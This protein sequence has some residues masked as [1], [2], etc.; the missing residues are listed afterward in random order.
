MRILRG[1]AA[2]LDASARPYRQRRRRKARTGVR[3]RELRA[4]GAHLDAR[5]R[6]S[7][8]EQT[9]AADPARHRQE[10]S[11]ARREHRLEDDMRNARGT[12]NAVRG[13]VELTHRRRRPEGRLDRTVEIEAERQVAE[14]AT[15][16]VAQL[17]E[18]RSPF[19]SRPA[20]W[21][22]QVPGK[23]EQ[24]GDDC[25]QADGE[26][27]R[28]WR[29][30]SIR[31]LE[32]T[33][34][35]N[36][37]FRAAAHVLD[38]L[39]G[40]RTAIMRNFLEKLVRG[41]A[42]GAAVEGNP[43]WWLLHGFASDQRIVDSAHLAGQSAQ[44]SRTIQPRDGPDQRPPRRNPEGERHLGAGVDG[45]QLEEHF[46]RADRSATQRAHEPEPLALD[47]LDRPLFVLDGKTAQLRR[48]EEPRSAGTVER[49]DLDAR[50]TSGAVEPIRVGERRPERLR[51]GR[52][53]DDPRQADRA[54]AHPLPV[55]MAF[56]RGG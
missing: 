15:A 23:V 25:L 45:P 53:P 35:R 48:D 54:A 14:L 24:A 3:A 30:P 47:E 22:D 20:T 26:H 9:Q 38:E 52:A 29:A 41:T 40:Q 43:R 10:D 5:H 13:V 4:V 56:E 18:R 51:S 6:A 37:R 34:P 16:V 2:H 12:A 50:E 46:D 11:G 28:A 17:R 44:R 39:F 1:S 7:A 42:E 32:G 19:G 8:D 33:N 21:T 55:A 49:L 31:Q 27:F 36:R